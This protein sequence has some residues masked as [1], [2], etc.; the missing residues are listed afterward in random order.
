MSTGNDKIIQSKNI[1]LNFLDGLPKHLK[2]ILIN[3]QL[4]SKK[5]LIDYA[6][7]NELRNLNKVRTNESISE[8]TI[9]DIRKIIPNIYSP[10]D[11]FYLNFKPRTINTLRRLGIDNEEELLYHLVND[12][13]LKNSFGVGKQTIKELMDFIKK[14]NIL[15]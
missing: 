1:D 15:T 13:V 4:Y 10:V 2:S 9:N 14:I 3:N 11:K 6:S 8:K 12:K 7:L 5:D